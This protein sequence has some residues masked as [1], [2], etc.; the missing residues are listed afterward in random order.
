MLY[1][2]LRAHLIEAH[3]AYVRPGLEGDDVAGIIMT[4]KVIVPGT[5]ILVSIDKDMKSI[6]GLLFIPGKLQEP[7]EISEHDADYWHLCQTLSGDRTDGYSGCPGV[8]PAKAEK[9]I[10]GV[11]A[12]RDMGVAAVWRERVVPAFEAAGLGEEE[13]LL[14]A[15]LARILRASDYDF[16]RREPKL[17]E[18]K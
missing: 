7:V 1:D 2:A 8:G 6:P 14:Q 17:W 18:P 9:I 15:R 13:A 4:S 5:K 10:G 16:A 3:K 11:Y 12:V